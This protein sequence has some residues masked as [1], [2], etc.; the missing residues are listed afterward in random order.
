M[1]TDQRELQLTNNVHCSDLE[2]AVTAEKLREEALAK[3]IDFTFETVLSTDRNLN[4]LKR[5][6]EQGYFVRCIY[7]LTS[8]PSI[9]VSRVRSREE[10]GGHG[11][12]E[13]RI[14][15]RYEKALNLVPQLMDVCD[16]M[17]IYDNTDIQSF[18]DTM[19]CLAATGYQKA[20]N[21]KFR[22]F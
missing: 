1:I 4:L 15:A 2:A 3:G 16:V 21:K 10:A 13:E 14:R 8:D 19:P 12:P 5:A 20:R 11:V 9:N 18:I 6:K 7:V 17:H 22:A